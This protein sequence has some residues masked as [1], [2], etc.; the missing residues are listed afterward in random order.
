MVNDQDLQQLFLEI[1][2][3]YTPEQ[4]W[5]DHPECEP[6]AIAEDKIL[7]A[8]EAARYGYTVR[9]AQTQ[10]Q[11]TRVQ[12]NPA[13]QRRIFERG[14]DKGR[15]VA[16]QEAHQ[17]AAQSAQ[18]AEAAARNKW[19]QQGLREGREQAPVRTASVDRKALIDEVLMECRV[20]GESN[21]QM[22]P[23][24]NALRHRLKKLAR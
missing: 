20:I 16:L 24:M 11:P 13:V 10:D 15:S 7:I 5:C 6:C 9:P 8:K 18:K 22:N 1:E 21:P 4:G 3:H 23:A 14:Y 12:S 17:W 19:Y 2:K